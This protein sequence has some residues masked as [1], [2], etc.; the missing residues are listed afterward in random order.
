MTD[1]IIQQVFDKWELTDTRENEFYQD[2]I[3]SIKQE[4]I[5]KIKE[6]SESQISVLGFTRTL[7]GDNKE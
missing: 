2:V 1:C 4:L 3:D 6:S 5:E 7:I